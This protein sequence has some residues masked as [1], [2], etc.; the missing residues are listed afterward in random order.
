V[1]GVELHSIQQV[2]KLQ[3]DLHE[4]R[5]R[6]GEGSSWV[7]W[8]VTVVVCITTA[9]SNKKPAEGIVMITAARAAGSGAV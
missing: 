6:A 2:L 7:S 3:L 9:L 1:C 5:K 8:P 4:Y